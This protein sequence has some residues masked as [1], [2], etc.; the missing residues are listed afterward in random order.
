MRRLLLALLLSLAAHLALLSISVSRFS[1][2][3]SGKRMVNGLTVSMRDRDVVVTSPLPWQPLLLAPTATPPMAAGPEQLD[4]TT[5]P[6][7]GI[8]P[9]CDPSQTYLPSSRL[10]KKPRVIRDLASRDPHELKGRPESGRLLAELCVEEDGLVSQ[11]TILESDLPLVFSDVVVRNFG[12][13]VF[14]PGEIDGHAVR[15]ALR[16]EVR[17]APPV[18]APP[19][20]ERVPLADDMPIR[21]RPEAAGN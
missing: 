3:A 4:S 21:P 7:T 8:R 9:S 5:P 19:A 10:S 17:F 11:V 14:S 6:S 18:S 13:V 16:I 20:I 15:S 12:Q 2:E 1:G